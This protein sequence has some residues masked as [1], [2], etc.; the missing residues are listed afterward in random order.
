MTEAG[1]LFYALSKIA[2][3]R[4]IYA[5]DIKDEIWSY[6]LNIKDGRT[7]G[8]KLFQSADEKGREIVLSIEKEAFSSCPELP[9]SLAG[10]FDG[11]GYEDFRKEDVKPVSRRVFQTEEGE[12]TRIFLDS[13]RRTREFAQ[14][15]KAR[16]LWRKG[17]RVKE[18]KNL[19]F[20]E[21]YRVYEKMKRDDTLD[22]FVANGF[23]YSGLS[24]NLHYPLILRRAEL[25]Y[26]NGKMEIV[27]KE[28]DTI[29]SKEIFNELPGFGEER[30][31]RAAKE[32]RRS[33]LHPAEEN[34]GE[35]LLQN[36]AGFLS[37]NCRYS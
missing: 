4:E 1:E 7:V 29:F 22:F 27:D 11:S 37:P 5:T 2:K 14:W 30:V 12:V 32:V 25:R 20:D 33:K 3:S 18:A 8:T 23:F 19:L 16:I 24:A 34:I 15:K 17:E 26:S 28:E 21:L 9:E 36:L 13:D 31:L 35:R 6:N 10:W